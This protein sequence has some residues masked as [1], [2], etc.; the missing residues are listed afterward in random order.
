MRIKGLRTILLG[1]LTFSYQLT[2][3]KET[4]EALLERFA[5][6]FN[7]IE[8]SKPYSEMQELNKELEKLKKYAKELA[9]S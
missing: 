6:L 1:M 4:R 2:E 8:G 9:I 3:L 5:R 7:G